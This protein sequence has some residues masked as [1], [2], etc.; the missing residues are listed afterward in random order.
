MP[1]QTPLATTAAARSRTACVEIERP[2]ASDSPPGGPLECNRGEIRPAG[3]GVVVLGFGQARMDELARIELGDDGSDR[4][5]RLSGEIDISNAAV[6]ELRLRQLAS[7]DGLLVDVSGLSYL[8]SSGVRLLFRLA[9]A[10]AGE[11]RL[12]VG[13]TS[14]AR[15]VL[16][17]AGAGQLLSLDGRRQASVEASEAPSP[18]TLR[19]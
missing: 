6:V 13:E 7:E 9:E 4:V 12:I 5:V 16:E 19:A 2:L 18:G 14:P 11:L 15:R 8:D 3:C 10:M 17:V 1:V